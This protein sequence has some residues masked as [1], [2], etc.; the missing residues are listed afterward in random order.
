MLAWFQA[1]LPK[2]EA[3]FD[4]FNAH[5]AVLVEGAEAL[6]T[7]LDGGEAVEVCCKRIMEREEAADAIAHEVL[8]AVRRSFITP[9]DRSDI[10]GLIS[11]MDDAIDQMQ[12]TAKAITLFE[13]TS[14]EPAMRQMADMIVEAAQTTQKA[15]HLLKGMNKHA[16]ELSDLTHRVTQLEDQSDT[17]YDD[18]MKALFQASRADPMRFIAGSEIYD[19]LEKVMD[20]FE[21]VADRISGIMTEHL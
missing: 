18:G 10:R 16:S 13:A 19:H 4:H 3:F 20:R 2:E 5:A 11:S 1:L 7:L 8:Q 21:D 17:I 12:K 14:F 9:F 6:R 15:A